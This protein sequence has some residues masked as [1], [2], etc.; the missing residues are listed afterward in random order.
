MQVWAGIF[1]LLALKKKQC[2]LKNLG[3]LESLETLIVKL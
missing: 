1:T 2:H 3:K